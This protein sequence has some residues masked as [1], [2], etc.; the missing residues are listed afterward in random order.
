MEMSEITLWAG[1]VL[2]F[3]QII[4]QEVSNLPRIDQS[5]GVNEG[6]HAYIKKSLEFSGQ[7]IWS[8]SGVQDFYQHPC[9]EVRFVITF[10]TTGGSVTF[11]PTM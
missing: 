9:T 1:L 6:V 10:V 2:L 5:S 11:L 3:R 8:Q 7:P 4:V